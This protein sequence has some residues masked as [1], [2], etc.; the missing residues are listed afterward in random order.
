[1]HLLDSGT[2]RAEGIELSSYVRR[3]E[4]A[5]V[6]PLTRPGPLQAGQR[7]GGGA[8][9]LGLAQRRD[10]QQRRVR[11]PIGEVAQHE[12]G[13][14]VCPMDVVHDNHEWSPR[15]LGQN[16]A[17]DGVDRPEAV[18]RRLDVTHRWLDRP[19]TPQHL[20]PR[21]ERRR[22]V[23]VRAPSPHQALASGEPG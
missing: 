8:A 14:L 6:K 15:H 3:A 10:E 1:M 16:R 18:L 22:P 4:S 23:G 2:G 9:R 12:Q 11:G 13:R 21:P 17:R 20:A 5:Q 19:Q 7:P